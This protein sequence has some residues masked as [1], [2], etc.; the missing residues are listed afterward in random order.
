MTH[1]YSHPGLLTFSELAETRIRQIIHI[2]E[3]FWDELHP[4][5]GPFFRHEIFSATWNQL[6][7]DMKIMFCDMK[8]VL[9]TWN[10]F[11]DMKSL[12]PATW[13]F[14]GDMKSCSRRHEI[15]AATWNH[16]LGDMKFLRRHEILSATWNAFFSDMK[17]VLAPTWNYFWRHENLFFVNE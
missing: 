3:E 8:S 15:F 14:L 12:F 4:E 10:H 9:A 7:G 1:P 17:S 5:S 13:N 11:P 16:F 6:F 2:S